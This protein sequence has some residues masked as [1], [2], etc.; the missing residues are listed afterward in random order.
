MVLGSIPFCYKHVAF[1]KYF[2]LDA[3]NRRRFTLFING[4]RKLKTFVSEPFFEIEATFTAENGTYKGKAKA[5]EPKREIIQELLAK[6]KIHPKSPGIVTSVR[7]TDKRTPPPQ[8]HS[9]VY[10]TGDS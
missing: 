3:F 1:E 4:K 10:I 2:Q 6:H 9:L 7:N 8:L 5:K